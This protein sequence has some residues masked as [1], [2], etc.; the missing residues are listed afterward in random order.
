[1]RRSDSL[2]SLLENVTVWKQNSIQIEDIYF[3]PFGIEQETHDARVIF[4]T[5]AHYDHFSLEDIAKVRNEETIL[6]IPKDCLVKSLSQFDK[7][8]IIVVEPN[9]NYTLGDIRIHTVPM[10]NISKGFHPKDNHWVG[11]QIEYNDILYYIVGD[12]DDT[13]ELEQTKCDVLFIPIGG[14][15]TMNVEEAAR[16]VLTINPKVAIP[17][18][19]G[20]IVGEL[21]D[22]LKFA[23]LLEGKI[24]T[25]I[26]LK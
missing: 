9:Q 16:A 4:I 6:I 10:Y 18:H 22:G 14:T 1:M 11:Y 12:S 23:Q 25:H 7:N 26:Y 21:S 19:Y 2:N 3:D 8:H 13:E 20:S 17:T 24:P 5:H 15:Y